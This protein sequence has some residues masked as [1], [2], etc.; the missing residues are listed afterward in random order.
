MKKPFACILIMAAIVVFGMAHEACAQKVSLQDKVKRPITKPDS[1]LLNRYLDSVRAVPVFSQRHQRY[2]D[3]A[4]AIKPWKASW[5]QQKAMPLFKQKKYEAGMSYL[6]S[7]VKYDAYSWI[8]YRAFMKCIF[9]K[10]YRESIRDFE[11]AKILIGAGEVMDHT[12]DFYIGLCYL[13]LDQ[14]DSAE[15]YLVK[16]TDQQRKSMGSHWVHP[17][18]LFYLGIVYYEKEQYSKAIETFD[19]CLNLY[20]HFSDAKFYKA[21]CFARSHRQEEAMA[22]WK[23]AA[24]DHR[25]GYTI[26]EDNTDYEAYPYQVSPHAYDGK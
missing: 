16:T 12:Y 2:L 11:A 13:Q 1:L 15:Y 21:M 8:D 6:D 18:D 24:D 4:L 23:D 25:L 7:A 26:N 3:S 17:L 19:T 10:S 5:W 22:M 14:F 20:T 9:Q